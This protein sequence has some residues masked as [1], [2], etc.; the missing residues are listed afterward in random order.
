MR[1]HACFSHYGGTITCLKNALAQ[2][3]VCVCGYTILVLFQ[4]RNDRNSVL[5]AV[6]FSFAPYSSSDP[7]VGD[8]RKAS[9][10]SFLATSVDKFRS[11]MP[12]ATPNATRFR[13]LHRKPTCLVL[14]RCLY[15]VLFVYQG[16]RVSR[17]ETWTRDYG[18]AP[19]RE[20]AD[21]C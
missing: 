8:Q 20:A 11:R 1:A 15:C 7:Y 6:V 13:E 4:F 9:P 21:R 3:K 17:G 16:W 5:Q 18:H 12:S 2:L 19:R 14:S 10:S